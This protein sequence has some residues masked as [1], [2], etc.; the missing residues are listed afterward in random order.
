MRNTT[1][2]LVFAGTACALLLQS[3]LGA[4]DVKLMAMVGAI[5]GAETTLVCTVLT[6][7]AGDF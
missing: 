6:M 7:A 2:T 3:A 5:L 1:N 4:G